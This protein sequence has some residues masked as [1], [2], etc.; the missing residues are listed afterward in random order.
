MYNRKFCRLRDLCTIQLGFTA[1]A[2][3][4]SAADG[5]PVVQL[6]DLNGPALPPPERLLRVHLEGR[7]DR[8]QAAGGDVLFRSRGAHNIAV[9]VD[10]RFIEPLVAVLPLMILR[11]DPSLILPDYLAWAINQPAAQRQLGAGAQGTNL[12]MVQKAML[13]LVE[14]DVPDLATQQRIIAVANLAAQEETLLHTLAATRRRLANQRLAQCAEGKRPPPK[15]P[16]ATTK[17]SRV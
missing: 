11:P 6:G 10:D 13:D 15:T 9:V 4:Q 2:R 3:F 5:V 7:L 14:L 8:Y 16:S 12:R 1:R 17:E